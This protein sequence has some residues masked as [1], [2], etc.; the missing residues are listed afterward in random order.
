MANLCN[1]VEIVQH[2]DTNKVEDQVV[3]Q[4]RYARKVSKSYKSTAN[5]CNLY[6]ANFSVLRMDDMTK[7]FI[8][9]SSLKPGVLCLSWIVHPHGWNAKPLL[10]FKPPTLGNYRI[11]HKEK[12]I[13]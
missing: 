2:K 6:K 3:A 1:Q 11:L 9:Y 8:P 5:L 13:S 4:C 12:P 7:H 10:N